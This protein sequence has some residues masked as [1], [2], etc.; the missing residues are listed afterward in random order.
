MKT[1]NTATRVF[2][3]FS[4]TKG[5]TLIELMV[6]IAVTSI[7]TVMT[8]MNLGEFIVQM[9]VD[10]EISQ[11]N[12]LLFI[13]RNHAIAS[14]EKVILCPLNAS[15]QC[16]T[17]WH[18]E[19]SVFIDS[20]DNK[21][22]D[23][24]SN[25]KIITVKPAITKG[26]TLKYGQ[27]RTKITYKPTGHLSGLANGTFKY[28]PKTYKKRARGIIVARSGRFHQSSD[29]NNDGFEESRSN[30]RITCS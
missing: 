18:E 7:L 28:C 14:G 13:T 16:T 12:R 25:E 23:S 10:N 3:F 20:N 2:S 26:D 30:N 19:L 22:F 24:L 5:F 6:S 9:R 17:N 27:G 4:A 15:Y 1:I 21:M 11:L 29:L 8:I